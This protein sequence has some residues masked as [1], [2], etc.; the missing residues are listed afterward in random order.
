MRPAGVY[1]DPQRY[2]E[3]TGKRCYGSS[4][5]ARRGMRTA[6]NTVRPYLCPYCHFWH[7]TSL[8]GGKKK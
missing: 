6:G 1:R 2:C 8:T 3:T 4:K 5:A 7:V